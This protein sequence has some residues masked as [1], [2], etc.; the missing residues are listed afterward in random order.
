MSWETRTSAPIVMLDWLILSAC[1]PRRWGPRVHWPNYAEHITHLERWH[2]GRKKLNREKA[3]Q[4]K[5]KKQECS[6]WKDGTGASS[7]R[8]RGKREQNDEGKE[9]YGVC[10]ETRTGKKAEKEDQMDRK[11]ETCMG[12]L[13]IML[14]R[15]GTREKKRKWKKDFHRE[16][17]DKWHALCDVSVCLI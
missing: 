10:E 12:K 1:K 7:G 6:F 2:L 5:K 3:R 9:Q 15:K 11:K 16:P 17:V 13:C 8:E 4:W 14:A